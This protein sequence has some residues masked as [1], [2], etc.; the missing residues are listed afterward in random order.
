VREVVLTAE[1]VTDGI[2]PLLVLHP[3]TKKKEA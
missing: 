2:P 3:E 1:S